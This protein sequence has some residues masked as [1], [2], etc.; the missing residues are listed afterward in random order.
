M[1]PGFLITNNNKVNGKFKQGTSAKT[2]IWTNN[3][4]I[5]KRSQS[6][7]PTTCIRRHSILRATKWVKWRSPCTSQ[8]ATRWRAGSRR[9]RSACPTKAI[10]SPTRSKV[11][12]VARQTWDLQT[13]RLLS[14]KH[15]VVEVYSGE[16]AGRTTH[17]RPNTVKTAV[18][19]R[20]RQPKNFENRY[21]RTWNKS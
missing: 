18:V 15:L 10:S 12:A 7:Y 1:D 4:S 2:P 3:Q 6:I 9:G 20:V 21:Q 19:R 16:A 13:K 8:W 14:R 5:N 17:R 11:T